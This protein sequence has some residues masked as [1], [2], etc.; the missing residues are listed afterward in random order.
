MTAAELLASIKYL[1]TKIAEIANDDTKVDLLTCL[2]VELTGLNEKFID[3][4]LTGGSKQTSNS[5][6]DYELFQMRNAIASHVNSIPEFNG[7][8]AVE[9]CSFIDKL[10]QA[11]D[12]FCI[13][14]KYEAPFM[15]SATMRLSQ[16]VYT[17][18]R[19]CG[20]NVS[21]FDELTK[22]LRRT[23][24]AQLTPFQ[25]LG[26]A[27]HMNFRKEEKFILYA[28]AVEKA[29]KT[30]TDYIFAEHK[31]KH[32]DKEMTATQFAGLVSGMLLVERIKEECPEIYR[33]LVPKIKELT[34]ASELATHAETLRA[35]YGPRVNSTLDS[36]A[37]AENRQG[38]RGNKKDYSR[39]Q[40]PKR[41]DFKSRSRSPRRSWNNKSEEPKIVMTPDDLKKFVSGNLRLPDKYRK[42]KKK[43][44]D[45]KK[46][47]GESV[48]KKQGAYP[49]Q[50]APQNKCEDPSGNN[51]DQ[52]LTVEQ[53]LKA[54][55]RE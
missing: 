17:N 11:H 27:W 19:N 44:Q 47:G 26:T 46:G 42:E 5:G 36:D 31:K 24:D 39:D 16:H 48:D 9:L 30:A 25:L 45:R 2:Q 34:T 52:V 55:F 41:H 49:V 29:M 28:Q 51:G 53:F 14:S 4:S 50:T 54:D 15:Q 7:T 40:N 35:Q 32:D 38:Y 20:D 37:F 22:W 21:T 1:K 3:L 12:T 10:S 43:W 8:D 23:Y 6:K 13:D 18:L 33:G